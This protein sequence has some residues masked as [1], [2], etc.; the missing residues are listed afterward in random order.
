MTDAWSTI[1]LSFGTL[2]CMEVEGN[3]CSRLL[4]V[5]VPESADRY[6]CLHVLEAPHL[7]GTA[8]RYVG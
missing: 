1:S 3:R 5:I 8:L 6:T 4:A 7:Q 2:L